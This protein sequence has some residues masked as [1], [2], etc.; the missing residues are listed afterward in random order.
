MATGS[1]TG[2]LIT[3]GAN[4][5]GQYAYADLMNRV[6]MFLG[7]G[8]D[9]TALSADDAAECDAAVQSGVRQF[10]FP[11]VDHQWSFLH[12]VTT[13]SIDSQTEDC[14]WYFGGIYGDVSYTDNTATVVQ[15]VSEPQIQKLIMAR[16]YTARPQYVCV[17]Q[18]AQDGNDSGATPNLQYELVFW[19]TP[20]TTYT[21]R[22]QYVALVQKLSAT[23][24]YHLGG[25]A[26]TETVLA[27]CLAAAEQMQ[28][29]EVGIHSARFQQR[30]MAS[31]ESDRRAT[32]PHYG[33]TMTDAS[34]E[35]EGSSWTRAVGVTYGGQNTE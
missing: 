14:P 1:G 13:M 2:T 3:P 30:L 31:V 6:S 17:R 32:T 8:N 35:F 28:D 16:P 5:A 24:P 18:K 22:L 26:H 29:D 19:P 34:I 9:Y 12:P 10:Y 33:G 25:V 7:F 20:D 11:P 4:A 15:V 23:Y 27:S 21:I